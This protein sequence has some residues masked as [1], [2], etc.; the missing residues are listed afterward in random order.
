[1]L[2]PASIQN[3]SFDIGANTRN[4]Q[5]NATVTTDRPLPLSGGTDALGGTDFIH[6]SS[7]TTGVVNIG[8]NSSLGNLL[9]S[10]LNPG[11][12]NVE[13]ASATLNLGATVI[14]SGSV[15]VTKTGAG[16]LT[17]A[18]ANTFG[19]TAGNTFTISSGTVLANTPATGSNSATGASGVSVSANATLG[20]SGQITPG[21]GQQISVASGGIISPGVG[22]GTLTLN[23]ANTAAPLLVLSSGAKLQ[24]DLNSTGP[25]NFQS[26]TIAIANGATGDVV[27]NGN[28]I[29][30]ND[31]SGG[32]LPNGLY[33][34]FTAAAANNYS[35]LTTD[36]N[37][38][39][40]A[41]LTIGTGLQ[42]YT[43]QSASRR[44][45]DRAQYWRVSYTHTN[46][47]SNG[48]AN[49]DPH[50]NANCHPNSNCDAD[51]HSNGHTDSNTY[52]PGH[53]HPLRRKQLHLRLQPAGPILQRR[54]CHRPKRHRLRR[55]PGNLQETN[56]TGWPRI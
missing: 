35:G 36:V 11:T 20:G 1:M 39:I 27:F 47:Y 8:T 46:S 23:G 43:S 7:G 32:T 10:F 14:F 37:G 18:G 29:N 56:R 48:D 30:F 21:A 40:T 13:N 24:F 45:H 25:G 19:S 50:P 33:T 4:L 41:G 16:T 26:D 6:L 5:A 9:L 54:E 49:S 34:L 22:L 53:Q 12:I 15:N 38:N 55:R 44:E 3:V 42:G 51:T 31:L 2:F 17:L 28:T 52:A